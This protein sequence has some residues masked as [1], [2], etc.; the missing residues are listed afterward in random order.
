M[1]FSSASLSP[2]L[3]IT[4][5]FPAFLRSLQPYYRYRMNMRWIPET[6]S[7]LFYTIQKFP[8]ALPILSQNNSQTLFFLETFPLCAYFKV[9]D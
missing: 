4:Y 1:L 9:K 6:Q 3:K 2:Y 5:E 7:S 8:I